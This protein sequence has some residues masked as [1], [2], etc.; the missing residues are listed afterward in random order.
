MPVEQGGGGNWPQN[1]TGGRWKAEEIQKAQNSG[2]NY[3]ETLAAG[4]GLKAFCSKLHDT[5]ILLRFIL[6]N[7]TAVTYS[8]IWEA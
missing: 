5:H 4:L 3:L 7:T 1:S 8:T 6:D 2:I